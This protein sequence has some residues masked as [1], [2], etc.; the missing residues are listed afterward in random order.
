MPGVWLF[1]LLTVVCLSAT[2]VRAQTLLAPESD[3]ALQILRDLDEA[4]EKQKQEAREAL[5]RSARLLTAIQKIPRNLPVFPVRDCLN[6]AV[7]ECLLAEARTVLDAVEPPRRRD[8]V[9]LELAEAE[10]SLGWGADVLAGAAALD[11][12]R[13]V[14]VAV[15]ALALD[16]AARGDSVEAFGWLDALPDAGQR[17]DTLVVLADAALRRRTP[18]TAE[19]ALDR[20]LALLKQMEAA[21]V[22]GRRLP[23]WQAAAIRLSARMRG[24]L[25]VFFRDPLLETARKAGSPAVVTDLA[26]ALVLAGDWPRAEALAA[27]LEVFRRNTVATA[28]TSDLVAAGRL[29][30]ARRAAR[31]VPDAAPAAGAMLRVVVA[32]LKLSASADLIAEGREYL[33]A[34]IPGARETLGPEFAL[35]AAQAGDWQSAEA[36]FNRLR[37]A[38]GRMALAW[39]L[40]L[41]AGTEAERMRWQQLA[42]ESADALPDG[43]MR[44][45]ALAR[46]AR[47]ALEAGVPVQQLP[48]L[49][50]QARLVSLGVLNAASRA[51]SFGQLALLVDLL[52]R[53]PGGEAVLRN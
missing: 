6:S 37:D 18:A 25:P 53:T 29:A 27:S 41:I 28:M 46:I 8:W 17:A 50:Q 21:S 14:A 9:W 20:L 43:G 36:V 42:D 26:R 31:L 3:P 30:E 35:L 52:R 51:R 32:E 2:S 19:Q 24:E 16:L 7:S 1:C 12:M 11:D 4:G 22:A 47:A 10:L 38:L 45:A 34:A 23:V 13:L 44:V 33:E 5:S 48:P 49:W 15:A 39:R 40:S